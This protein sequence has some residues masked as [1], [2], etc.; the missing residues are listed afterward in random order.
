MKKPMKKYIGLSNLSCSML[1]SKHAWV[2]HVLSEL[3]PS[4]ATLTALHRTGEKNHNSHNAG[5]CSP[6]TTIFSS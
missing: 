1:V 2:K 4:I 5:W 3:Q 6:E